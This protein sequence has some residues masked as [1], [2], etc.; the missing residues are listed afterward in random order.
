MIEVFGALADNLTL[1]M[2]RSTLQ[3]NQTVSTDDD[4]QV[5]KAWERGVLRQIHFRQAVIEVLL[6]LLQNLRTK[7]NGDSITLDQLHLL[8]ILRPQLSEYYQP[9]VPEGVYGRMMAKFNK[10]IETKAARF[11]YR[12]N[13]YR[14]MSNVMQI[15]DDH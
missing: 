14:T 15:S 6:S 13:V 2:W 11:L 5:A 3:R 7:T 9:S 8:N 10:W 12:E 1:E 4:L